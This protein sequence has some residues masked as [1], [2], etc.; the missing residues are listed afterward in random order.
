MAIV[1]KEASLKI[2]VGRQGDSVDDVALC[3]HW[4]VCHQLY[5][6]LVCV[7]SCRQQCENWRCISVYVEE[8]RN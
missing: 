3:F 8:F 5:L 1:M 4:M 6:C 7:K 2:I